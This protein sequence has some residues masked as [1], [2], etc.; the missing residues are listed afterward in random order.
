[1]PPENLSLSLAPFGPIQGRRAGT[2]MNE[3]VPT[4]AAWSLGCQNLPSRF[5]RELPVASV[6]W[7]WYV[8]R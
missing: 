8:C 5:T 4:D 3:P 6:H 7:P 2:V 1:M